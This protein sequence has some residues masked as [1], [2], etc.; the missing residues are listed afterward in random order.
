MR[1]SGAR[2]TKL[3]LAFT[4]DWEVSLY[5]SDLR[6]FSSLFKSF[7]D[8]PLIVLSIIL[9]MT[10]WVILAPPTE[11]EGNSLVVVVDIPFPSLSF[12][13]LSSSA[14]ILFLYSSLTSCLTNTVGGGRRSP[15]IKS[16]M[17]LPMDLLQELKV[18]GIEDSERA[19]TFWGI[20]G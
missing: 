12:L 13:I 7:C 3:A 9:S 11:S 18:S 5:I 10:C 1:E 19:I 6:E 2:A 8:T 16:A 17:D 4:P 15:K 14:I 20:L